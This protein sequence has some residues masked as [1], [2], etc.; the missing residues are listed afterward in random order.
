MLILFLHEFC[1][2]TGCD[3]VRDGPSDAGGQR[4]GKSQRGRQQNKGH[5]A[6]NAFLKTTSRIIEREDKVT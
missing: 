4:I 3:R 5:N 2:N 6:A 1:R